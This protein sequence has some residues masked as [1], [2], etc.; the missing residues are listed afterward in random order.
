MK[1]KCTDKDAENLARKIHGFLNECVRDRED[2]LPSEGLP[3]PFD[4]LP[5]VQKFRYL[6]VARR[7]IEE[8]LVTL[9]KAVRR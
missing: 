2:R 3:G 7:M 4:T 9:R 6:Y 5:K 1:R 8:G